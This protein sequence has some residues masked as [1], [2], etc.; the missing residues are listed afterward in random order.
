MWQIFSGFLGEN[1]KWLSSCWWQRK[2]MYLLLNSKFTR[3]VPRLPETPLLTYHIDHVFAFIMCIFVGWW[4][5]IRIDSVAV[6]PFVLFTRESGSPPRPQLHPRPNQTSQLAR[7]NMAVYFFHI[8]VKMQLCLAL[9]VFSLCWLVMLVMD[10]CYLWEP[11][12]Q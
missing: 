8:L 11:S 2:E 12:S 9:T 4:M 5:E 1:N 6:R 3:P 10:S 7:K